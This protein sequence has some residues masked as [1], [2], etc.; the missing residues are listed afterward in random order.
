MTENNEG[1]TANPDGVEATANNVGDAVIESVQEQAAEAVEAAEAQDEQIES[2]VAD[3]DAA[4]AEQADVAQA[5][6]GEAEVESA[7]DASAEPAEAAEE[8]VDADAD[9]R[10]RLRKYT[11]ELKE[12]PGQWYIIQCYSGYENKVKT[13]L[14]MRAQTLE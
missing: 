2:A 12:L 11:K 9:Y 8:G 5:D 1:T 3:A 4:D 14:D 13:N 7:D 10:R 6:A